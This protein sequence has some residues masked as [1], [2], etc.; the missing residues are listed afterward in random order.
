LAGWNCGVDKFFIKSGYTGCCLGTGTEACVASSGGYEGTFSAIGAGYSSDALVVYSEGTGSVRG[1]SA[2]ASRGGMTEGCYSGAVSGAY[3]AGDSLGT[4]SG[5]DSK[6]GSRSG[7]CC[8]LSV[9]GIFYGS[10]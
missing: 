2:A 5:E 7:G 10:F 9:S 3:S 8:G 1:Y 4:I 6:G